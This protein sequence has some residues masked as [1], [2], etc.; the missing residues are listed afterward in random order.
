M[1]KSNGMG[2]DWFDVVSERNLAQGDIVKGLVSYQVDT[3]IGTVNNNVSIDAE[4]FDGIVITQSCDLEN[5][6]VDRILVAQVISWELFVDLEVAAGNTSARGK[7][8][9]KAVVAGNLPGLSILH[10]YSGEPSL[11]WSIA[12][13]KRLYTFDKV[14]LEDFVEKGDLRLRMRSPYREHLAQDSRGT[15]CGWVCLMTPDL[16]YQARSRSRT[17]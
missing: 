12:N 16:S 4:E 2:I 7:Q 11:P 15:T 17:P 14:R 6:K 3:E 10:E 13:F 8:Y 9:R 5:D 1:Q